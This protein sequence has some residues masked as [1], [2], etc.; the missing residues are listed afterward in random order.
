MPEPFVDLGGRLKS[1]GLAL[2]SQDA[3]RL[4][5][6]L[7]QGPCPT[8]HSRKKTSDLESEEWVEVQL[9][10]VP[11]YG[12]HHKHTSYGLACAF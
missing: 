3:L 6:Q 5:V 8:R 11:F 10:N 4:A 7:K 9:N 2:L 1:S 12:I